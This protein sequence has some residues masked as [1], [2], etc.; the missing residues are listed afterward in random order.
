MKTNLSALLSLFSIVFSLPAVGFEYNPS[1]TQPDV[2]PTSTATHLTLSP[3]LDE[4][5]LN[6]PLEE[7]SSETLA[8]FFEDWQ[9]GKAN[10]YQRYLAAIYNNHIK[11]T[12]WE[13]EQLYGQALQLTNTLLIDIQY[14]IWSDEQLSAF[15]T[16]DLGIWGLDPSC[17]AECTMPSFTPDM[18]ELQAI[19]AKTPTL[20]DDDF[21]TLVDAYYDYAYIHQGE[22]SGYPRFFERTWDYGGYSLLGAEHHLALLQQIEAYQHNHADY[23]LHSPT[24]HFAQEVQHLRHRVLWDILFISDCSGLE[25]EAI[26]AE[27]NQIL[28]QVSL[29]PVE[30]QALQ[31]RLVIFEIG[32]PDIQVN[33]Q[34]LEQCTCASG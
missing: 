24:T 4:Q 15:R 26:A 1:A 14:D 25:R 31:A 13:V 17:I 27:L 7:L 10:S 5:P 30:R 28:A 16:T 9:I 34:D 19:A 3:L 20:A 11:P 32:H 22:L 12:P 29:S 18:A 33:C 23:L 6:P 2:D 21:F 8:P